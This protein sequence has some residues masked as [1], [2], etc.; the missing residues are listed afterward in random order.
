M[1]AFVGNA[2]AYDRYRPGV[3]PDVGH[4][5]VQAVNRDVAATTL[6][7]VGTGTGQAIE[8]LHAFF[9]D[10]TA[11][12][13]DGEMLAL[14]ERKLRG[15]VARSTA[16]RLWRGR[17]E[18]F[19]PPPGWKASLVTFCRSFH[20]VDQPR[21]LLQLAD[22]VAPGGVIAVLSDRSFWTAANDWQIAPVFPSA[23]RAAAVPAAARSTVRARQSARHVA[24][25]RQLAG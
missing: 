4:I 10:I 7:D 22:V 9:A 17:I 12:D 14:A 23:F 6:L 11:V 16:L 8:S 21:V 13:P 5:L 20:W 24:S 19:E 15:R 18:D 1:N 2:A 3:P 25:V